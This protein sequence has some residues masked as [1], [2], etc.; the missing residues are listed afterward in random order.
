MP[1]W[2]WFAAAVGAGFLVGVESWAWLRHRTSAVVL[3]GVAIWTTGMALV[4]V[5]LVAVVALAIVAGVTGFDPIGLNEDSTP[6]AGAHG[7]NC[8]PNYAGACL[9]PNAYDYDCAGGSGDGPKY[10][11]PVQVVGEDVYGLDRDGDGTGC[12]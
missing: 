2:A 8:D 11:G 12:D 10:T 7:R 6:A 1:V 9:D 3:A 4:G 5:G